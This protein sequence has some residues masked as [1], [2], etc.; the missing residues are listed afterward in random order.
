M[1]VLDASAAAEIVLRLPGADGALARIVE[2]GGGLQAPH[3]LD[4]EVSSVLRRC[5]LARTV[6][7]R[8]ASSAL[9]SFRG[10]PI[11]RH[12]HERLLDRIW[13]L[14]GNLTPY[15]AAYVS[16]AEVLEAPLLTFDATL[17]RAPGHR[18]RIEVLRRP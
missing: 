4:L 10:L 1:I 5:V 3:L 16:L 11:A 13:G 6:T 9:A 2:L 17:G 12:P 14:R 7:P 18:A 8:D 15:D